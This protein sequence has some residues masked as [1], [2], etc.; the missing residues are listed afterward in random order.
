MKS[1]TI[2]MVIIVFIL[3]AGFFIIFNNSKHINSNEIGNSSNI[4]SAEEIKSNN[5]IVIINNNKIQNEN[6]ID[7]FIEKAIDTNTEIQ[8]LNI[9]QDN[10]NI[11]VTYTPGEFAKAMA[12]KNNKEGITVPASDGS[13]DSNK[14][15][16]G[17]YTLFID[18]KIKGEYPLGSHTIQRTTSENIVTLYFNA[19]LIDYSTIPE[20]CIYSLEDSNY[21]KKFDLSYN[22]RK[23]LGIKTMYEANGYSVK[24]FGGDVD[25]VI[26]GDMTYFLEKALSEKVI[27]VD[28]ILEQA[29]IDLKYGI[30]QS[31][32]YSDGG[33]TEYMY[34]QYTIL[35]LN[36]LE[37]EKDLIIGMGGQIINLYNKN[38]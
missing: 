18:G 37:N 11:K 29:K 5:A 34:N 22:Q 31:A 13:L 33:S 19:P 36:T 14:K 32:Y 1:K 4:S 12:S 21:T 23:D 7:E 27:T 8:E 15:I 25:I 9:K 16:Y 20:I 6:L 2:I 10:T 28:D 3:L 35:K 24:T 17:Y 26:N 38:K 30:C